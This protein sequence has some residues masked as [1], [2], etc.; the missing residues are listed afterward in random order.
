MGRGTLRAKLLRTR[1]AGMTIVMVVGIVRP[2]LGAEAGPFDLPDPA[3]GLARLGSYVATLAVSFDGT[4][5]GDPVNAT[6]TATMRV[7]PAGRGLTIDRGENGP[8]TWRAD[9]GGM[10]YSSEGDGPCIAE[11]IEQGASLADLYEPAAQLDSIIETQDMGTESIG[12]TTVHRYGFDAGGILLPDATRAS[13]DV[14]IA[15]PDGQVVRYRLEVEGGSEVFGPGTTGTRV[16]D[17]ELTVATDPVPIEVPTRC[18]PMADVPV[19]DGAADVVR[20]PGVLTFESAMSLKQATN[21]Y[22]KSLKG[23]KWRSAT[24]PAVTKSTALMTFRK[25]KRD[26]TVIMQRTSDAGPVLVQAVVTE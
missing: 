2:G 1:I 26:L 18:L 12:G 5:D 20:R 11:P 3:V 16:V 21:A 23:R 19:L 15:E 9:T 13:G 24:R 6:T 25:G 14:W 4:V 8:T 22:S 17:Y 7:S 10:S